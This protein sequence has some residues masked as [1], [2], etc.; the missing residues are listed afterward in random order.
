MSPYLAEPE[1]SSLEEREAKVEEAE[2]KVRTWLE[3]LA[4]MVAVGVVM[5]IVIVTIFLTT[6]AGTNEQL[7]K[8]RANSDGIGEN[9]A[10]ILNN[11]KL[12]VCVLSA[13]HDAQA[14]R[15]NTTTT[16][17]VLSADYLVDNCGLT[18]DEA[19]RLETPP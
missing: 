3:V 4:V 19:R 7:S 6:A 17:T 10:I 9:Q 12:V 16:T 18:R 14:T 5:T 15:T 8:V 2:A 11:H 1:A 13:V